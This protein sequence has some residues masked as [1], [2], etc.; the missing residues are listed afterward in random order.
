MPAY[1]AKI[2]DKAWTADDPNHVGVVRHVYPT[3]D[4]PYAIVSWHKGYSTRVLLG[5]LM[6]E[7][8]GAGS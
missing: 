6:T 5:D 3:K 2:G 4:M 1:D 8:P 7:W